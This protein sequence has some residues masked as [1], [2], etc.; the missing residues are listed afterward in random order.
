MDSYLPEF[1]KRSKVLVNGSQIS[2]LSV[3]EGKEALVCLPGWPSSSLLFLPF[4]DQLKQSGL[5][6]IA[7]DLPGWSGESYDPKRRFSVSGYA[8]LIVEFLNVMNLKRVN[9]LGYSMGGI[10]AE[11]VYYRLSRSVQ[12]LILISPPY[13]LSRIYQSYRH[14]LE[15]YKLLGNV[16]V[17][18][19]A[20]VQ[21]YRWFFFH[22][23]LRIARRGNARHIP[24]V[25][26][27]MKDSTT[28]DGEAIFNSIFDEQGFTR[29][30]NKLKRVRG[31]TIYG[32]NEPD[33]VLS[34]SDYFKQVWHQNVIL[35]SADHGHIFYEPERSSRL[36][37]E[38]VVN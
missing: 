1:P 23:N 4:F 24:L 18:T 31:L 8:K 21:W 6:L 32:E 15:L 33:F 26:A 13:S 38:F 12:R 14:R 19:K 34:G 30:E 11:Q 22:L 3:G 27:L 25:E 7:P 29:N 9:L 35:P 36:V 28:I 20:L 10:I 5:R 37:R 2:Y 17:V 16:P